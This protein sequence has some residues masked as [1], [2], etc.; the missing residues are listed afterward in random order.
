MMS[1]KS[2]AMA[3][4]VAARPFNIPPIHDVV[5]KNPSTLVYTLAIGVTFVTSASIAEVNVSVDA[6]IASSLS[7]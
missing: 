1:A 4:I 3:I 2:T 6:V 7:A 5:L